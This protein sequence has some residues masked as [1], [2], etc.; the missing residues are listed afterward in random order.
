M[1]KVEKGKRNRMVGSAESLRYR[2]VPGSET[3]I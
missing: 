2:S 1:K 3:R